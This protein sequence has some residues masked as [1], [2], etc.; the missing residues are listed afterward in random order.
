M[1]ITGRVPGL[2]PTL[3]GRAYS[4]PEFFALER[5]RLFART[6]SAVAL[7]ADLVAGSYVEVELA[8]E[9]VLVLRDHSR[10]VRS[11]FNV[12][13]HR[14][15]RLCTETS[16]PLERF[17]RCPYHAWTYALD[18]RLVAGPGIKSMEGADQEAFGLE[19]VATRVW[20]GQIWCCVDPWPPS[21]EDSIVA[22]A[23][24]RLGSLAVLD[25]YGL[26]G[27]V[28]ASRRTYEVAANW[29]LLIENFMECYHCA[30]IHPELTNTL[31]EFRTGV[32]TQNQPGSS[33]AFADTVEAFT[34]SGR[35]GLGLLPGLSADDDRR[36][37]GMT[38][39]PQVFVNLLPDHVVVHR[40]Q[41]V[42]VDRSII[43][44]DWLVDRGR[45]GAA[46]YDP[47]DTI[48]LFD[49]VNLQD[50]LA[51]E[52]CQKN[53]SSRLY[54]DGGVLAATEHHLADFHSYVLGAVGASRASL[55]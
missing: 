25:R 32:G 7:A 23:E 27:L 3:P 4:D 43:V 26:D 10:T 35:G 15:S 45:P 34:L 16:G 55:T 8:G 48:A 11:F 20:Q 39:L 9:N 47:Q 51:C 54:A 18:G 41:P 5:E 29:K 31:P 37:Y 30:T 46:G 38:L 21:F 44:C 49:R 12:C 24:R 13:R 28:L 52:R 14:G 42:A 36:Y 53:M 2:V 19:P 17:I 22:Q 33:A 40:M 6:W 1:T 50:F